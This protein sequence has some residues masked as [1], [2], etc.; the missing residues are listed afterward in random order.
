MRQP[1]L[2]P[3]PAGIKGGT[4]T[5]GPRWFLLPIE[6]YAD[7]ADP[8]QDDRHRI[9]A[10]PLRPQEVPRAVRESPDQ[11]EQD[12]REEGEGVE[13]ERDR[14][15]EGHLGHVASKRPPS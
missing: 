8:S 7:D 2:K 12:P 1:P 9:G 15:G 10:D 3:P 4:V 6:E 11:I 13:P 5:G 14:P